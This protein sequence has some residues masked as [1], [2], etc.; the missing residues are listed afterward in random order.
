MKLTVIFMLVIS[1]FL[2]FIGEAS[3][4]NESQAAVLMLLIEPGARGWGMGKA[5]RAI[6]DDATAGFY[7]PAGLA[8]LNKENKNLTFMHTNWLPAMA[9]DMYYD[10]AG[11]AQH[12]EGWGNFAF[13]LV[14]FTLGD[15][16]PF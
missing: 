10:Y 14:Y 1:L 2:G 3:A 16:S 15:K 9:E 5:F 11:Y 8:R 12:F 13:N 6:A 4:T 7:N